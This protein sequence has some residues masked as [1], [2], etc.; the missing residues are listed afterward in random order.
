MRRVAIPMMLIV[1]GVACV[2]QAIPIPYLDPL[3]PG[4]AVN[5]NN[6]TSDMTSWGAYNRWKDQD[7]DFAGGK[8]EVNIEGCY[9]GI[10]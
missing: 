7:W 9:D 5:F 4:L 8:A 2:A 6:G 3:D 10:E 1:L